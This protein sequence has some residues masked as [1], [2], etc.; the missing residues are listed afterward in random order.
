MWTARDQ[1]LGALTLL[2]IL[3]IFLLDLWTPLGV[4]TG[5][6]YIIP[7]LL[8]LRWSAP[9]W[10]L[11][12]AGVC[13]A[14]IAMGFVFSPP[15]APL[16]M[17]LSNRF[18]SILT[19]WLTVGLSLQHKKSQEQVWTLQHLLPICA[20]CKSLRG[21]NGSWRSPDRYLEALS[22]AV[23]SKTICPQCV[24]K[25]YPDLYPELTERYPG[26]TRQA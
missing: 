10:S 18:L 26:L 4:A 22:R 1:A 3:S 12:V 15:G 2:L 21:V 5:V 16:W 9:G 19:L 14:L 25:W 7:M 13:T 8:A 11:G 23:L 6:L 24:E 20:S 17:A